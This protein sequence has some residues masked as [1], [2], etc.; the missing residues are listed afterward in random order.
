MHVML[1]CDNMYPNVIASLDEHL[2]SLTRYNVRGIV[3]V[4]EPLTACPSLQ[5]HVHLHELNKR[6]HLKLCPCI[7]VFNKRRSG[8][9]GKRLVVLWVN[10]SGHRWCS[11]SADSNRQVNIWVN[12]SRHQWCST[13]PN[14][15]LQ[16]VKIRHDTNI[17]ICQNI[18]V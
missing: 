12:T 5:H 6:A 4:P 15:Y 7:F 13:S 14:R 11:A 9:I 8:S 1:L 10:T 2:E 18:E 16:T 17:R 3:V